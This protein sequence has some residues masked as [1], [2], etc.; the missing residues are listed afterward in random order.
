M[1]LFLKIGLIVILSLLALSVL[2][3]FIL[4]RSKITP[5]QVTRHRMEFLQSRILEYARTQGELPADL[6]ALARLPVKPEYEH[7]KKPEDCW[8]R[9]I[10]YEVDASGRITLKSF[11]KDGV[12]GGSGRNADIVLSFPSRRPDGTWS[13]ASD[14]Y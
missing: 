11:G 3:H 8:R 4:P 1:K 10:I 13:E 9:K 6:S 5:T 2:L 14:S 12:P 7:W